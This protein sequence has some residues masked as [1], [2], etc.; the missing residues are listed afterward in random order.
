L[1]FQNY[2]VSCKLTESVAL[3]KGTLSRLN[4]EREIPR[5]P[6]KQKARVAAISAED[7]ARVKI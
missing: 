7:I 4:W 3:R 2:A 1:I 6:L 5:K